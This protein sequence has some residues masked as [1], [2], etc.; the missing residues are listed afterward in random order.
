[1]KYHAWSVDSRTKSERRPRSE[2]RV[3]RRGGS[4]E[5]R[6][7]PF[8]EA[9]LQCLRRMILQALDR[10]LRPFLMERLGIEGFGFLVFVAD[11]LVVVLDRK[12][13]QRRNRFRRDAFLAVVRVTVQRRE[14]PAPQ[15]VEQQ[16][17]GDGHGVVL[18]NKLLR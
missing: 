9:R 16:I 2:K 3:R 12:H 10:V 18:S 6:H 14:A 17:R 7:L 13:F 8:G 1:M 5:G 15:I 4:Y 11:Q